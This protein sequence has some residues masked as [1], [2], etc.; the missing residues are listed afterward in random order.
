MAKPFVSFIVPVYNE[1]RSI[2]RTVSG[3]HAAFRL[4]ALRSFRY[5]IIAVDDGSKDHS[6]EKISHLPGVRALH[7]VRNR[8]YGAALKTGLLSAKGEWI[9]ITDADATYPLEDIPRLLQEIDG[10]DMVVGARTGKHVHV[11]LMRRPAKFFLNKLA[12]YMTG[13]NIPDLNSGFRIFKKDLAMRFFAFFPE[14]F[15]FTTTIT[16]ASLTNN[17]RVKFIPI[18]YFKR[19][20]KSSIKAFRDFFGFTQLIIRLS[21]YFKPLNVFLPVSFVLFGVGAIKLLVD[22][23]NVNHFGLGGVLLILTA[24]Q[25]AFLGLLAD[26]ILRRTSV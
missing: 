6:Y 5:E 11:P 9:F 16:I 24:V 26:L 15:S 14:G 2:E 4:P 25:I 19:E 20:G 3:I 18:N 21:L 7:H 13:A 23:L 1:E 22:Y 12:R 8:G 10:F 17:Y